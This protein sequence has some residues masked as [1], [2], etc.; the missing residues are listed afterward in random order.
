MV[1][2]LWKRS[3]KGGKQVTQVLER[4]EYEDANEDAPNALGQG[5]KESDCKEQVY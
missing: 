4:N 3:W 2:S 5:G 1:Q